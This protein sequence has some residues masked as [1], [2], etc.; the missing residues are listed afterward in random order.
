[1]LPVLLAACSTGQLP[2]SVR[3]PPDAIPVAADPM[4]SAI[5]STAYTFGRSSSPAERARAAALVEYLA[6]DYRW[7]VRWTEY[8]PTVGPALDAARTELHSALAIAPAASPQAAVDGLMTIWR[9]LDRGN[10]PYLQPA[11]FTAP[12]L[13]MARLTTPADLP[14]TRIATAMMEREL[15]R[16]DTERFSGGGPGGTGGGGGA[17]P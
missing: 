9:S 4:R 8:S 1:M 3:L 10:E 2:P 11:V 13:T 6:T 12:S 7:D 16:I 5:M 14:A 15:H 17:H